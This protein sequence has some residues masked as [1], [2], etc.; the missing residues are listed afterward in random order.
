V[1]EK[2]KL[3]NADPGMIPVGAQ[4]QPARVAD[5]GHRVVDRQGKSS[6]KQSPFERLAEYIREVRRELR[7]VSWPSKLEVRNTTIITL[8]AVSFFGLYLFLVDQALTFL[9]TQLE[10]FVNWIFGGA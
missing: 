1:S 4:A 9:L 5:S 3:T 8:V 10:H 6:D 2:E 7:R